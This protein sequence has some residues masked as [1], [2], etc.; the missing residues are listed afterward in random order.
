[1]PRCIRRDYREAQLSPLCRISHLLDAND[2]E[3]SVQPDS[4]Q[5]EQPAGRRSVHDSR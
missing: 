3:P 1:V 2:H 4:E 5:S